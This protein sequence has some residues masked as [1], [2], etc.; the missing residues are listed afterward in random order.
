[1]PRQ[2]AVSVAAK[3]LNLERETEKVLLGRQC[4]NVETVI[5]TFIKAEG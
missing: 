2:N 5:V 3:S 1:M 4:R